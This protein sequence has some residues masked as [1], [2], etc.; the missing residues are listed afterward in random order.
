MCILPMASMNKSVG[1]L[2]PESDVEDVPLAKPATVT[3]SFFHIA[4]A[5]QSGMIGTKY[6]PCE[7]SFLSKNKKS[8]KIPV[9]VVDDGSRVD[10]AKTR[11]K[12]NKVG[13]RALVCMKSTAQ[14]S[15]PDRG[16]N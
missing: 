16:N 4:L 3:A 5:E 12:Q 2:R 1:E 8:D 10:I 15:L 9:T 13:Q 11:H 14:G 7:V 6:E